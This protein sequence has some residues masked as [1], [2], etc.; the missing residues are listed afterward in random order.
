RR[1]I[2]ET[3]PQQRPRRRRTGHTAAPPAAPPQNRPHRRTTGR[4]AASRPAPADPT[5]CPPSRLPAAR[6]IRNPFPFEN[7]G[8]AIR[9]YI[10]LPGGGAGLQA[11]AVIPARGG[12]KGVP[13]KNVRLLC[14]KPL[15]AWTIE[16]AQQAETVG[17]VV[18]STDDPEI[19]AVSRR[20]GADVVHRPAALSG[21]LSPSEQALAHAL[22]ATGVRDGI[23]VFLQ[24]TSP[25][26]LPED[27]DGTVR[28]LGSRYDSAFAA[29]RRR[30]FLWR[31]TAG[32]AEPVGHDTA[33]RP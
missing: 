13:R 28:A 31:R 32:G 23:L 14:G 22:D 8:A 21:D 1:C 9:W 30:R 26:T 17:R 25:L 16:A 15:I 7:P 24:C 5:N 27:I 19:A 10:V 18:V 20:W 6:R 12:S 29:V 3:S 33:H 11:L 4:A 2:L